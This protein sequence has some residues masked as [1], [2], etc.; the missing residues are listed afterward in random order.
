[1]PVT[2]AHRE[3]VAMPEVQDVRVGQIRVLVYLIRIVRGDASL[4]S[5]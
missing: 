1:M 3:K 4:G 2:V 5:K